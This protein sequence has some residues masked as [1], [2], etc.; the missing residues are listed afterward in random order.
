M[1]ATSKY[2]GWFDTINAAVI[3]SDSSKS[4]REFMHRQSKDDFS[5]GAPWLDPSHS[6]CKTL[7][8][9]NKEGFVLIDW[10][11]HDD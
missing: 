5:G 3:T 7:K 8:P 4:A 10:Y 2:W 6:T 1:K 11:S 9:A